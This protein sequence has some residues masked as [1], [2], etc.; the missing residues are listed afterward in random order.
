MR[1]PRGVIRAF[2]EGFS[3]GIFDL[4]ETVG[5]VVGVVVGDVRCGKGGCAAEGII[6]VGEGDAV[7]FC[8]G[9]EEA[10]VV[11]GVGGG[12]GVGCIGSFGGG[13]GVGHFGCR[14]DGG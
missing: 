13:R 12:F 9:F 7:G 11:V 5:I 10:L 6:G 2:E 4:G 3:T 14:S 8:L 1:L